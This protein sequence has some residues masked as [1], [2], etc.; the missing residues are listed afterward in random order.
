[1]ELT[2]QMESLPGLAARQLSML[3]GALLLC[4]A[5]K[6]AEPAPA[7]PQAGSGVG[8]AQAPTQNL[9]DKWRLSGFATLG[10]M[11]A[12]SDE[13]WT[14]ARDLT[15]RGAK[16]NDSLL[17][18]SRLGLQLHG[19]LSSDVEAVTQVVLKER[20]LHAPADEY[21][22]WAFLGLR[23]AQNTTVRL[24]RTSPD[25]FLLA[26]VRNVGIAYPWVRPSVEYYGWMPFSSMDGADATLRWTQDNANW[27]VKLA[28]GRIRSTVGVVDRDLAVPVTGRDTVAATLSRE[29]DGLLV[30]ATYLRTR[31]EG[32]PPGSVQQLVAAINALSQQ[33]IPQ[34][35]SDAAA[36]L[37]AM[38]FGGSTS[39]LALGLQYDQG[40]WTLLVEGSRAKLTTG[41]SGGDR[42][43]ASLSY[44]WNRLTGF[45]MAARSRPDKPPLAL[46][47]DWYAVLAPLLGPALA[48]QT[49][50][51]GA[52]SAAA[53][54][55][56]RF[57]Q[58][59]L[60]LG[61]RWDLFNSSAL[62]LQLD[63]VHLHPKGSAAW[64]YSSPVANRARVLSVAVD[65][66]F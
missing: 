23:P 51:L 59:T 5:A 26:D 25:M 27:S 3:C 45:M 19:S 44:R 64:R 4:A 55:Q 28:A 61:L 52:A 21:V 56:P 22:E 66:S 18:D 12:R 34:V 60:S 14:F 50:M 49:A 32:Q 16:G 9:A 53:A 10:W 33:N 11:H 29:G 47:A 48:Q 17:T 20:P 63:E 8:D 46:Q 43:Y 62:K 31:M 15:Q 42:G 40:P 2:R 54:N 6:A 24:G 36:I 57:D 37:K 30:K 41:V 1:M 38:G 7:V 35:S 39:Y 13:P 65:T 58:S